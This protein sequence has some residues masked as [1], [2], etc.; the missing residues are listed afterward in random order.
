MSRELNVFLCGKKVGVLCENEL[1]QLS[2]KYCDNAASPLSVNLP[3]QDNEYT[4]PYAF[5]FFENLTPEGEAFDILTKDHISGNKIFSIL[6]R[7]GGDCA[8]AV[9]FYETTFYPQQSTQLYE[10]SSDKVAQIIEKLPQDPLFTGFDNP[11]RLSLAGAQSK[12]AVYKFCGKYYRSNDNYPTTHIIKITN[13]KFPHLLENE[14]FCIKLAQALQLDVPNIE[15]KVTE[16]CPGLGPVPY[17]EIERFD[18]RIEK[19]DAAENLIPSYPSAVIRIH[20]EDFCQALGIVSSKKYQ[21]G[22]GAR[23]KDCYTVIEKYSENQLTDIT[24]FTEW[25][26]YNYFIGNTDA[27]AKNI[28]LLHSESGIKLAPFYDLLST[29][30]YTEKLVDHTMAMLINGKGKYASL[31]LNDFTALFGQLGLNATNMIKSIKNKFVDII[32]IAENLRKNCLKDNCYVND[33]PVFDEI[34]AIIKKRWDV[35]FG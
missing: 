31:V 1:S 6:D 29:E 28:S 30:V 21:S 33:S 2:F 18:R 24:R 8:G 11:P 23:L 20:Q 9:S 7:F 13:K 10:I 17:L 5:P 16:N 34:I 25:I 15:L 14:F 3:L 19:T 35:L 12:F 27:H 32:S 4:H 22:G 26:I